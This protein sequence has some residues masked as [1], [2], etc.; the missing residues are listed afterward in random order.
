MPTSSKPVPKKLK[1]KSPDSKKISGQIANPIDPSSDPDYL[2]LVEHYQQAE[3]DKCQELLDKLEK[4]YPG[5][6]LYR[7]YK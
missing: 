7:N 4:K 1:D 3:F 5:H 6:P 2:I